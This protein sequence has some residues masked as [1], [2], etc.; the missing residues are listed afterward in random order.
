MDAGPF[1]EALDAGL[2]R[3]GAE[4][5]AVKTIPQTS[6]ETQT[7]RML[8]E[9]AKRLRTQE[10]C[11]LRPHQAQALEMGKAGRSFLLSSPTASGKSLSYML[12][13]ATHLLTDPEATALYVSPAKALA[14]Q[15]IERLRALLPE[16]PMDL[17]DGDTPRD[18]RRSIK[19]R[20]RCIYTNPDMLHVGILPYHGGWARFLRH[21]R[22][23]VLDEAHQYTGAFGSHVVHV[24]RRLQQLC[25]TYG[26]HPAYI[27]LSATIGNPAELAAMLTGHKT[28]VINGSASGLGDRY[29]AVASDPAERGA[30]S[31]FSTLMQAGHK[32]L[33][34]GQSRQG[35]ELLTRAA[36]REAPSCRVGAYRSGYEP[37]ERRRLERE[38]FSGAMDGMV[39]TNALELGIDVGSLDAV[40]LGG[41][42]GSIASMWQQ[43]GR[44]GRSAKPSLA[45]V[46]LGSSVLE[47]HYADHP[48]DLFRQSSERAVL[49]PE[50]PAIKGNHERAANWEASPSWR[51]RETP[52]PAMSFSL[53]SAGVPYQLVCDGRTVERTD[54]THA[55]LECYPGAVYLSGNRTFVCQDWSGTTVN[56]R[57]TGAVHYITQPVIETS[58]EVLQPSKET[59]GHGRV[60]VTRTVKSYKQLDQRTRQAIGPETPVNLPPLVMT[61]DAFWISPVVQPEISRHGL[62][63]SLH[64]AEHVLTAAMPTAVMADARDIQGA[65]FKAHPAANGGPI[66][67]VYDDVEGGISASTAAF[68]SLQKLIE[69]AAAAIARCRCSA[70]CP[71]CIQN[72]RCRSGQPLSKA[73]A[74]ALLQNLLRYRTLSA[75]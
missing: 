7:T 22:L 56:L 13:M 58:I 72:P 49:N 73:G 32:T 12:P 70:G 10:I 35:V 69:T 66:I 47:Q 9:L 63:G 14:Q 54:A 53:R 18:A 46:C 34:F 60:T 40:V 42:P 25:Q 6:P 20:A 15:Q 45:V 71:S 64:A 61:T 24:L 21:L 17:Y 41:F 52:S 50:N 39:A 36:M 59:F 23:V 28:A 33:L 48:E 1:S 4:L 19:E 44:A 68:D 3:A 16:V 2:R 65:S 37:E 55:L 5:V 57:E 26:S 11:N 8:G 31:I 29:I 74:Q 30:L 51:Q 27:L 62:D 67:F 43:I 75:S 38:L